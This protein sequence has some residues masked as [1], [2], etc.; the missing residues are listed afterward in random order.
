MC[1]KTRPI[2]VR[3]ALLVAILAG[4]GA[5]PANAISSTSLISGQEQGAGVPGIQTLCDGDCSTLPQTLPTHSGLPFDFEYGLRANLGG[6]DLTVDSAA[7]IFILGPVRAV[8]SIRF[9]AHDGIE[10]HGS[11]QIV[12]GGDVILGTRPELPNLPPILVPPIDAPP[13]LPGPGGFNPICGCLSTGDDIRIEGVTDDS[14]RIRESGVRISDDGLIVIANPDAAALLGVMESATILGLS[15]FR[16]GDIYLDLSLVTLN[17]LNVNAG[18]SIVL[19][20]MASLSV[21]EPGT[22]VLL[23]LGLVGLANGRRRSAN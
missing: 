13:I 8:D 14:E 20:D 17:S 9:F 3:W 12:A 11:G 21:P 5:S 15:I 19:T 1:S 6:F 4:V 18:K 2:R 23:G 22:T 10:L 16:D 7:N